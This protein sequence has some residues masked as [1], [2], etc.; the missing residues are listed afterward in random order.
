MGSLQSGTALGLHSLRTFDNC[1]FASERTLISAYAVPH[2]G[3][4]KK[5]A[6]VTKLQAK[7]GKKERKKEI[8]SLF[9]KHTTLCFKRTGE[10]KVNELRG[11]HGLR[12]CMQSQTER[13]AHAALILT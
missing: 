6:Q 1:G 3:S 13:E 10:L 8:A 7:E 11:Q 4:S 5:E 9:T 2:H 12:T